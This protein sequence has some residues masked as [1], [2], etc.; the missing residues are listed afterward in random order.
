MQTHYG[1]RGTSPVEA[2]LFF[3]VFGGVI[4]TSSSGILVSLL[5]EVYIGE[6]IS[7][8]S[9]NNDWTRSIASSV[10]GREGSFSQEG[11]FPRSSKINFL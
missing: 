11:M 7:A 8:G 4:L 2:C 6:W 9:I 3:D 1:P 5:R 10:S